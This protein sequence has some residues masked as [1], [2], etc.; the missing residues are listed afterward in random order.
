MLTIRVDKYLE[1]HCIHRC[2]GELQL[3]GKMFFGVLYH[4]TLEVQWKVRHCHIN[5]SAQGHHG[6]E[7]SAH[8]YQI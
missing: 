8:L 7:K 2:F 1:E 3:K 5:D 4:V 6:L